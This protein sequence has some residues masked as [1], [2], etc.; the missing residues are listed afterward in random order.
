[1]KH[2]HAGFKPRMAS[3]PVAE[4]YVRVEVSKDCWSSDGRMYAGETVDIKDDDFGLV[5]KWAK[6]VA[7][8]KGK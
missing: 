1:M 6:R 5:R 4:G 2:F 8:P 7:E 3:G